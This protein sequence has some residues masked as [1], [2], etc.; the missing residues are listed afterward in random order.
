MLR[1]APPSLAQGLY[2][3]EPFSLHSKAFGRFHPSHWPFAP[4]TEWLDT[5]LTVFQKPNGLISVQLWPSCK[6]T[7]VIKLIRR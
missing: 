2:R 7:V 4:V 5:S 3:Q 6:G 1:R